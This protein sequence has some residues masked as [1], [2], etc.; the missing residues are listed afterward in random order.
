MSVEYMGKTYYVG[1][2][3]NR[4]I[5][6]LSKLSISDITEVK[7][8]NDLYDLEILIFSNNN[9]SEIKGLDNLTELK[10]LV[11]DKNEITEIRGLEHLKNLELLCVKRNPVAKW[12]YKKFGILGYIGCVDGRAAVSYCQFEKMRSVRQSQPFQEIYQQP[13]IRSSQ[14][15]IRQSQQELLL[16]LENMIQVSNRIN[17][18]MLRE[19]LGVESSVFYSNIFN[20]AADL[21][22]TV[23]G[24]YLNADNI[25]VSDFVKAINKH[26]KLELKTESLTEEKLICQYCGTPL[27]AK[28]NFCPNCGTS[29][30]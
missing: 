21:G 14:V 28:K 24:D 25:S 15:I 6:D 20:I 9:I 18:N 22:L 10:D 7:G 3:K 2:K 16:S 8:L 26:L 17:I 27:K 11:L 12:A 13:H 29:I 19:M 30:E 1:K 5:L 4:K 23:D